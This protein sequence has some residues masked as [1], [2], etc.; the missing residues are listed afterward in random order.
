[1]R[2]ICL[3]MILMMLAVTGC[4]KSDSKEDPGVPQ[5]IDLSEDTEEEDRAEEKQY[6]LDDGIIPYLAHSRIHLGYDVFNEKDQVEDY[7]YN[8]VYQITPL[9]EEGELY[10]LIMSEFSISIW[11]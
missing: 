10:D 5:T 1:M 4:S 2:K 6:T 8:I 3:L 7:S 11:S 9:I